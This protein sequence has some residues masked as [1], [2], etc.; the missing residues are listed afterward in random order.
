MRARPVV[1]AWVVLLLPLPAP[2]ARGDGGTL[3]FSGP[4]GPYRV[5]V[6]TAP[7]PLRV[8]TADVSVLV[9]DAAGEAVS[10]VGVRLTLTHLD[11]GAEV[12]AA[13]TPEA[14]VNKL[15]RAAEVDLPAAG[16]WRLGVVIDGPG[17]RGHC[18]VDLEVA[19]PLPRWREL[20]PWVAWP[21]VPVALFA[22]REFIRERRRGAPAGRRG[23]CCE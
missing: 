8:G 13:A 5:S 4:A 21:A 6:F 11:G 23:G 9:Q 17:G 14:A 15:L 10:G 16:R 22:L 20:W 18:G 3:R 7:E 2:A 12:S 1:V 19:P